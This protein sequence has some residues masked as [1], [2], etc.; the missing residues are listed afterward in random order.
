ML[1]G[2]HVLKIQPSLKDGLVEGYA[3]LQHDVAQ[4]G[5]AEFLKEGELGV[6]DADGHLADVVDVSEFVE[7]ELAVVQHQC[8]IVAFFYG[9]L[10][11]AFQVVAK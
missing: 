11:A 9:L 6:R 3:R 2:Y 8:G 7:E 4:L 10:I 5:Q 1:S